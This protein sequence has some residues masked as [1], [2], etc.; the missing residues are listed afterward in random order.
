[1]MFILG[2]LGVAC[3]LCFGAA[4]TLSFDQIMAQ[5]SGGLPPL[6][7]GVTLAFLQKVLIAFAVVGLIANAAYIVLG[8]SVRRGSAAA[9]MIGIVL[10]S[11]FLLYFGANAIFTLLRGYGVVTAFLCLAIT[12]VYGLQLYLLIQALRAS[13]NVKHMQAAYQAQYWQYMQQ[14]QAYNAAGYNQN[15]Y[16]APPTGPAQPG[17]SQTGWQWP[18]PPPPPGNAPQNP[19]SQGG[20]HGQAPQ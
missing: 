9:S 14:Q 8:L 15:A 3:G 19:P 16:N 20:P 4:I 11:L 6:P 13:S 17:P 5:Q 2:G 10:T 7:P 12:A 18:A 1:M